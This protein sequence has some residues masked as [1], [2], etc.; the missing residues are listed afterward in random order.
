MVTMA[1]EEILSQTVNRPM[2]G[3]DTL[4]RAVAVLNSRKDSA[5]NAAEDAL[6]DALLR[7]TE[8]RVMMGIMARTQT[9][10]D[11]RKMQLRMPWCDTCKHAA[12]WREGQGWMHSTPEFPFGQ[13]KRSDPFGDHEVTVKQYMSRFDD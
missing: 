2:E 6:L 8:A 7:R 4:I 3:D 12:V 10:H 1:S 5:R 11:A 13:P 9:E